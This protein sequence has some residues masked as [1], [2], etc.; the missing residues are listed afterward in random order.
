MRHPT[1]PLGLELE[2]LRS[3]YRLASLVPV[4][5]KVQTHAAAIL[6]AMSATAVTTAVMLRTT[7][8][9]LPSQA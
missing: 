2:Q 5:Q 4:A 1:L 9:R 7:I 8:L 6:A 3:K